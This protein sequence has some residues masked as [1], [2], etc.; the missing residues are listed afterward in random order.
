M[1]NTERLIPSEGIVTYKTK[2]SNNIAYVEKGKFVERNG[3]Y[4]LQGLTPFTY[5]Q[6]K[7]LVDTVNPLKGIYLDNLI[8]SNV[9]FYENSYLSPNLMWVAK[10]A[11]R[12]ILFKDESKT[13]SYLIPDTLFVSEGSKLFVYFIKQKEAKKITI[14]TKVYQTHFYNVY[15][16]CSVCIGNGYKLGKESISLEKYIEKVEFNFFEGSMFNHAHVTG[17]EK[18]W[19]DEE[20]SEKLWKNQN[21][22]TIGAILSNL[23]NG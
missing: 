17:I 5:D 13:E 16:N 21:N 12:K 23:K 1:Q 3:N 20:Y 18:Y 15:D 9:L 2:D 14:N 7:I 11:I 6:I 22:K 8:P 10:K 4:K 19:E